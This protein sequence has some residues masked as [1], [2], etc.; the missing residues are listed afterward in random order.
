MAGSKDIS[1]TLID[2]AIK[3]GN[4]IGFKET[5]KIL[6]D[7]RK[8]N[9][10]SVFTESIELVVNEVLLHFKMPKSKLCETKGEGRL[11]RRFCYVL[12]QE[13]LQVDVHFLKSH[14]NRSDKSVY[15]EMKLFKELDRSNRVDM[16]VLERYDKI[17][18]KIKSKLTK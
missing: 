4:A 12:L 17:H 10:S 5:T 14:F 7:L 8:S 13:F 3:T 2:E 1:L 16:P 11:A 15:L 18:N 9:S 6:R